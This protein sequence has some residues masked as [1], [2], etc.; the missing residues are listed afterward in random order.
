VACVPIGVCCPYS[1]ADQ[2]S[3]RL[4]KDSVQ[5]STANNDCCW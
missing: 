4:D 1:Y 2:Y 3:L 5:V